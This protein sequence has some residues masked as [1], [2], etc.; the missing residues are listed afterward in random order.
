MA[1]YRF[2]AKIIGRSAGYVATASAAYR[3]A[4]RL[5]DERTGNVYDYTR[6]Q[7]VLHSEIIAPE[8]TPE[9]MSDRTQLWNAVEKAEKRKD[10]QLARDV[11][12]SLPHELTHEQRIDLVQEFVK[13]E[14]VSQGMIADIAIHAPDR[15]G[16]SRNHHAHI[17]LTMRELAGDGFGPK[18]RDWN[19]G[20]L[21][22]QWRE[23]W[24]HAV[25]RQLERYGHEARVDHRSLEDQ[26][27]DREPEPKQGPVA[28]EMERQGRPSHAGDDR[29]AAQQRNS[30]RAAIEAELAALDGKVIDLEKE[31]AKRADQA[32]QAHDA[33]AAGTALVPIAEPA[34]AAPNFTLLHD[35]PAIYNEP[36]GPPEPP[37]APP[38]LLVDREATPTPT[39]RPEATPQPAQSGGGSILMDMFDLASEV[40]HES[41]HVARDLGREIKFVASELTRDGRPETL[42]EFAA[43]EV[44]RREGELPPREIS[45]AEFAIDAR[46]R[47]AHYAQQAAEAERA[48]ALNQL[49]E[50]MEAG[51]NLDADAL[52]H[53][54]RT[55]LMEIRDKG[56]DALR[57]LIADHEREEKKQRDY[58]GYERERERER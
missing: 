46:A 32:D 14:F 35:P 1:T 53:L 16:D 55:D 28:T 19:K 3:S 48:V 21:L 2:E 58:G 25:N 12:V 23:D 37:Q 4:E 10:S 33:P 17:M 27:I 9:W 56:D 31:R 39:P 24:A 29:R 43:R 36:P 38:A 6:K 45:P 34:V 20:E 42:A 18:A 30:E 54:S 7:G 50:D 15:Q 57:Q 49:R 8:G 44:E 41:F 5:E 13:A 51:R 11:L 22:E 52:R 47:R 26:G 40:I